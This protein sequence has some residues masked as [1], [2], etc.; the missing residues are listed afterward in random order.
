MR[1]TMISRP[2]LV[3][4]ALLACLNAAH[5]QEVHW[6]TDYAAALKESETT[7]RPIFVDFY[8]PA[9]VWC[10]RLDATTFRDPTVASMLNDK[11]VPLK[12]DGNQTLWLVQA[13]GI[14]RYP[15]TVIAAPDGTI[16]ASHTGYVDAIQLS[17][18]LR[19]VLEETP[20]VAQS[21]TP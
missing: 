1:H 5:A 3:V 15:S 21:Q 18:D 4:V 7:N 14:Q 16:R 9:C 19:R 20:A 8:T 2:L 12:I 13:L 6:R 17:A 11:F 10:Q